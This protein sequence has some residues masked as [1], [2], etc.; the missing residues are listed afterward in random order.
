MKKVLFAAALALLLVCAS[1]QSQ[2]K[3]PTPKDYIDFARDTVNEGIKSA[4][5]KQDAREKEFKANTIEIT[6]DV[7]FEVP[8]V[9]RFKLKAYSIVNNEFIDQTEFYL[10]GDYTNLSDRD[11]GFYDI[12]S[13]MATYQD[14]VRLSDTV[15]SFCKDE[16]T[17][18][19]TDATLE[20]ITCAY[21][22][23][24]TSDIE[25]ECFDVYDDILYGEYTIDIEQ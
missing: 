20:I 21:L 17:S 15:G 3:A 25:I 23:N 8:E 11:S 2:S 7:Y 5:E 14:G 10:I 4:E 18:L 22:R 16:W 24:T 6:E 12:A 1:C 9:G 13:Y 19:K